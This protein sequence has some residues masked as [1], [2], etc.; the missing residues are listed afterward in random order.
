[1]HLVGKT[2]ILAKATGVPRRTTMAVDTFR[3]VAVGP[4]ATGGEPGD[5]SHH[6]QFPRRR[7]MMGMVVRTIG[8]VRTVTA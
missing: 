3:I 7:L 2:T 6:G 8:A 4:E 1:M 5:I